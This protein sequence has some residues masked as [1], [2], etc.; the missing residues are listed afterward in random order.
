[1]RLSMTSIDAASNLPLLRRASTEETQLEKALFLS[2]LEISS[3]DFSNIPED[4]EGQH[5]QKRSSDFAASVKNHRSSQR[6]E[7]A[8]LSSLYH[9]DFDSLRETGRVRISFADTYQGRVP[10]ST[11]GCTVIAPLLCIH[12]LLEDDSDSLPATGLTDATILQVIDLETPAILTQ[13]RS[14]L[15]LSEQAFLIPADAHDYLIDKGQL[16][17]EQFVNVLGGNILDESHLKAMVNALKEGKQRSLAATL[18]FHEHVVAILKVQRGSGTA[19]YDIIDSLPQKDTMMRTDELIEDFHRRVGLVLT[20]H[21]MEENFLPMTARFRCL[22]AE[23]LMACLR[24]FA[25]SKFSEENM[26]YIDQYS[27]DENSCDFD[28]RVFQAFIWTKTPQ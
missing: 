10:A 19:W 26:S 6:L 2:G 20:P 27:W 21:E 14:E 9:E 11:N 5:H 22:D 15:N 17:Q 16:A 24:W 28:P 3:A 25:C 1:M 4:E 13:L 8:T 7:L 12:H 18:F 23:S